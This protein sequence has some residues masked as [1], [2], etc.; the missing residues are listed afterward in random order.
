MGS[1][2]FRSWHERDHSE[3]RPSFERFCK[4]DQPRL[5]KHKEGF[6]SGAIY[7]CNGTFHVLDDE[8]PC[9]Q[10][11]PSGPGFKLP[12]LENCSTGQMVG[13]VLAMIVAMVMCY[14][15]LIAC[16]KVWTVICTCGHKELVEMPLTHADSSNSRLNLVTSVV[17]QESS[18]S[19]G[20]G[21]GVI[22]PPAPLPGGPRQP[23]PPPVPR[24]PRHHES[25]SSP[26]ARPQ[27]NGGS[28]R[29]KHVT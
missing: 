26:R 11:P 5:W 29:E 24:A 3:G 12:S 13:I 16:V 20:S 17:K 15:V 22:P 23:P 10:F 21:G 7:Q 27:T 2:T 9:L 14:T 28:G 19:L 8:F 4:V 25:S 1:K 18:G 6:R